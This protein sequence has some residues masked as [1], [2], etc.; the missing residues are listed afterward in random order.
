VRNNTGITIKGELK[1]YYN[2]E[3][4]SSGIYH[5]IELFYKYQSYATTDTIEAQPNYQKDYNVY[6]N[7]YC[8]TLKF[9]ELNV[10]KCGIVQ[11]LSVGLGIRYRSSTSTL[12]A[13]ENNNILGIGDNSAN[14]IVNAAGKFYAPNIL[15]GIKLGYKVK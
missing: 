15:I 13:E 8:T 9:G 11:D 1:R 14:V 7:V 2:K 6:K 4:I 5:S 10:Y 12:T 3:K